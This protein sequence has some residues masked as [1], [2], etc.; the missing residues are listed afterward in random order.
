ME[1]NK[2]DRVCF[3]FGGEKIYGYVQKKQWGLYLVIDD[4]GK[5]WFMNENEL[6]K[7]AHQFS[8]K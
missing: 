8:F 6:N 7:V 1:F 4:A 2:H 5:E 3:M